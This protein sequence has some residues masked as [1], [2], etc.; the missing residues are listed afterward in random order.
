MTSV[1]TIPQERQA[2]LMD[3]PA[4]P[5]GEHMH[6]LAALARINTVSLT[7]RHL[8]AAVGRLLPRRPKQSMVVVVLACGMGWALTAARLLDEALD[9]A[10]GTLP[11]PFIAATRYD[12][13]YRRHFAPHYARCRWIAR[14]VRRPLVVACAAGLASLIPD[15][16][17]R[18]VPFVVGSRLPLESNA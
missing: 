10:A 17:A 6:A 13:A 14:L 1:W 11:D 2:E 15:T 5:V 18:I 3:D 4:L 9:S 8:A 12:T 16:A 7:A